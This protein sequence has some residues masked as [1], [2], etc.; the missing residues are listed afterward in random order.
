VRGCGILVLITLTELS[1][2]INYT[3]VYPGKPL[4]LNDQLT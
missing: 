1:V 3:L 4:L 2:R